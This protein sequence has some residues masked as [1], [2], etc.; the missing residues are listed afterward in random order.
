MKN[1]FFNIFNFISK[2]KNQRIL[3]KIN[4]LLS[5]L[6]I[7][8]IWNIFTQYKSN[9]LFNLTIEEAFLVIISYILAGLLWSK[10][11]K[12]NYQGK[13]SDYFYN[14]SFSKIGKFIPTGLVT[15]T[16]RLNQKVSK[17]KTS[18][19]I[20][21]GVLEEQFLFPLVSIPAI[22]LY[23]SHKFENQYIY[24]LPI[25]FGTFFYVIKFLYSKI[26]GDK[27][28]L[29]SYPYLFIS[30][31]LFQFLLLYFIAEN[32]GYEDSFTLACY[33]FL[34]SS[35]GLFFIGV[36]AGIGIREAIFLMVTNNFLADVLLL[37]YAIK[38]RLV[39]IIAD[40]FFGLIGFLR[41]YT[42]NTYE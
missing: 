24:L 16:V 3:K 8:F 39:F 27:N 38:V 21:Y 33:Y 32:M 20:F 25:Y 34:S 19:E 12:D 5:F 26:R 28:T 29:M 10:Y 37:D 4:L 41:I 1:I 17:N 31:L 14:W 42:L 30:Y 40:L 18:K 2:D 9:I 35:L 13:L 22:G 36:P 7:Y 11:M 23:L 15:L 6:C